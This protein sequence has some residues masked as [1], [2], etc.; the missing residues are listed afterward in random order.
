VTKAPRLTLLVKSIF[1]SSIIPAS[2]A[3]LGVFFDSFA[4]CSHFICYF[5]MFSILIGAFTFT[6]T[7]SRRVWRPSSWRKWALFFIVAQSIAPLS[8]LLPSNTV[9]LNNPDHISLIWMN[10][11]F[12][13][14]AIHELATIVR[15]RPVDI[16][17]LSEVG[18]AQIRDVFPEYPYYQKSSEDALYI[19]SKYPLSRGKIIPNVND[20]S[21]LRVEVTVNRRQF[22]LLAAHIAW[23]ILDQHTTTLANAAHHS[24][25]HANTIF[26]GDFN[27]APW[28]APFRRLLNEAD[29]QHTRQGYGLFNSWHVDADKHFGIPLD[30]ILY[31]GKINN[32]ASEL[33]K[34]QHS[35]HSAMR[36]EFDLGGELLRKPRN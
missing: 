18:A 5:L 28:A 26:V 9:T 6:K 27:S 29:L 14:V 32:T 35:D 13:D 3:L 21:F 4:I 2:F 24:K 19:F 34:T 25:Q 17:V 22:S 12:D 20:R 30:H 31:R 8:L 1:F 36:A 10:M 23:P 33:I 7:F 16:V 15:K 11:H